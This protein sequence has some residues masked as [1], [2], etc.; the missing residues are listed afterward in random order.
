[1]MARQFRVVL[2]GGMADGGGNFAAPS[3][4]K[5]NDGAAISCRIVWRKSQ[6]EVTD[7]GHF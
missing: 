3:P 1:M 7:D 4:I 5:T 6:P 2:C